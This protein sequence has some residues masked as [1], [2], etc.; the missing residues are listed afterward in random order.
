[1]K[2][3]AMYLDITVSFDIVAVNPSCNKW[4]PKYTPTKEE[5]NEEYKVRYQLCVWDPLTLLMMKK[6]SMQTSMFKPRII[7]S[8][9]L[10][11]IISLKCF[12]SNGPW[13]KTIIIRGEYSD[14]AARQYYR[15]CHRYPKKKKKKKKRK[16]ENIYV[17]SLSLSL[18]QSIARSQSLNIFLVRTTC[19][20]AREKMSRWL[21]SDYFAVVR[22]YYVVLKKRL[23][24]P[25]SWLV[26]TRSVWKKKERLKME[27]EKGVEK[28]NKSFLY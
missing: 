5:T 25:L 19:S 2:N 7:I 15:L 10:N 28:R 4:Y 13:C 27:E 23:H 3:K 11:A 22:T 12:I 24:T 1:M 14:D 21:I 9:L 8:S 6:T 20:R 18:S 17:L 16:E 26:H